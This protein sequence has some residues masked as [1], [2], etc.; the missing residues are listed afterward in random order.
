[1][2]RASRPIRR[3]YSGPL[4]GYGHS[5]RHPAKIVNIRVV[6]RS[7][8]GRVAGG[9]H[10]GAQTTAAATYRPIRVRQSSNWVR[11]AI[12]ARAAMTPGVV[13]PGPAIVEQM[14]TTT[15]V[16]PGWTARTLD[17]GALLIER[18]TA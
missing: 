18:E 6:Q 4:Q 11:A 12:W 15:L 8:R 3:L 2:A 14:D 1:M 13:V 17:N 7:Q 9:T 10:S 5:T 16:E